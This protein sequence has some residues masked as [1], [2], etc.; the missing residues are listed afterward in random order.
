ME[1]SEDRE[2][3]TEEA[4]EKKVSDA[5]EKGNVPF[6]RE[7]ALFGSI[8]GIL[9][10]GILFANWA[11]A[12]LAGTLQAIL[13][14]AGTLR[15]EDRE[16]AATLVTSLVVAASVVVLPVMAMIGVGTIVTSLV[17]NV[18]SA[19]GERI[20]P[21][22]SRI[23][24]GAGWGR[25][26]GRNGMVEFGKS[27]IKLVAASA[28]TFVTL[29]SLWP[30]FQR[31][32][33]IDPSV[34]PEL[35]RQWTVGFIATLGVFALLLAVG[36]LVWSRIRWRRELR[37]S[38]HEVKEEMKQAEG[39]P[40]IKARIRSIARQRSS[41]RMLEKMPQASMVVVNPTHY[42]VALR[43]AREE[44]GAPVV[45]AKG[46]DFLALR[47]RELAT[48]HDI[49][50]VEN[51]PLARALYDKVEAG[52]QIPPEFYRAVAEIIHFLHSRKRLGARAPAR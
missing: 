50:I 32:L 12:R 27:I 10:A 21:R 17:Q 37:M 35:L 44:G 43:Y 11:T 34:L 9:A 47:I 3:K 16:G 39:D 6:A 51:K 1:D 7:A 45:L 33:Q 36:D 25:L 48:A 26:F 4:T 15:L 52:T 40:Y 14:G 41:R 13:D 2:S 8:A 19:A 20:T 49:P 22:A 28:L 30:E 29:R 46:V 31:A 38:R 24:P 5:V 23:S 18:P 42:A